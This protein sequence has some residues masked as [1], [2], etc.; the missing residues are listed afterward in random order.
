MS[1]ARER[2]YANGVTDE[3]DP[4]E[5]LRFFC[6]LAMS[7]QDWIDVE[8]FFDEVRDSQAA[9]LAALR[10]DATT[11]LAAFGAWCALEFRDSL[12]D[13]D[14]G[15][16]QDTMERLGVLVKRVVAEP[17]GEGCACA[18]YGEFPHDCYVFPDDVHQAMAAHKEPSA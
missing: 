7:R 8:P 4:V 9:E 18:E 3:L 1:T 11:K 6:S 15:S 12:S 14:G 16:A 10:A 13:V 5:R 2:F 17:C